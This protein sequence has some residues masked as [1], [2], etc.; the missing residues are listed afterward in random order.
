MRIAGFS[1]FGF[2]FS[3]S[4]FLRARAFFLLLFLGSLTAPAQQPPPSEYQVKA[5]FLFNFA[6]FVEW[7]PQAFPDPASP[8]TIGVV[9]DNPFGD[10]LERTLR[11]KAVNGH[12]IAAKQVKAPSELRTCHILFIS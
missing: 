9:G 5:A 6:K 11:N 10:D 7:P 8:F 12:P 1:I 4:E 2:Q 3:V